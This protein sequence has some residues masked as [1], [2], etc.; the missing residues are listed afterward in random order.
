MIKR[1]FIEES[2]IRVKDY[3]SRQGIF[4]NAQKAIKQ[5]NGQLLVNDQIVENWYVLHQGDVLEV[6]FPA[7]FQGEHIIGVKGPLDILYEDSY[8][9]ILNKPNNLAT[10]PTR[11]HYQHSLANYVMSYYKRRGIVSNIHFIGRLDYATSGIVVLAK[12]PYVM[13]EMK[14]TAMLKEYIL[15]VEGQCKQQKGVI[16]VGIEKDPTSIIK[17]RVTT[18]FVNSKTTYEV[19]QVKATTSIVKAT[20]H[21]GKTHQLRLHFAHLGHCIVGDELYGKKASD[22]ILHLH[23]MHIRFVHPILQ[24]EIQI[25]SLPQWVEPMDK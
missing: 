17:R 22:G 9:L 21:T 18:A 7:S 25:T 16:E 8:L 13:A 4:Q 3:L 10:I 14:T 12:N 2:E 19:L 11:L 24:Q 20:L 6:V 5:G 1:F 23:S 15:E